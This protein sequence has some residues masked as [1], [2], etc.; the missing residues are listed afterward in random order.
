MTVFLAYLNVHHV[1]AWRLGKSEE[2]NRSP[3][4]DEWLSWE[5]NPD[6]L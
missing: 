3:G 5:L 2:G 1:L 4:T 6:L